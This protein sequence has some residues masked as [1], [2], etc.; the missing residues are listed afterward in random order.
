MGVHN[1]GW[2]LN[3]ALTRP[4]PGPN[5][6]NA[7]LRWF[8]PI[9]GSSF[10]TSMMEKEGVIYGAIGGCFGGGL[11]AVKVGGDDDVSKTHKVSDSR[12]LVS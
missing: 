12:F 1:E 6:A 3:P 7:K 4:E 2:G 5:P 10:F 9:E 8:L 11:F